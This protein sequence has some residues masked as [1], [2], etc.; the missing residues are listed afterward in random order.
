MFDQVLVE[1]VVDPP[2]PSPYDEISRGLPR[3]APEPIPEAFERDARL[4]GRAR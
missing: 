2:D 3:G 4:L 1:I